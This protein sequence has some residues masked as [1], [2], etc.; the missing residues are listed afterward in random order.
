MP[1]A[2][3]RGCRHVP[4]AP[5]PHPATHPPNPTRRHVPPPATARSSQ[6][7]GTAAVMSIQ[8]RSIG[9]NAQSRSLVDDENL[10]TVGTQAPAKLA[11][12]SWNDASTL[13]L[14]LALALVPSCW[15]TQSSISSYLLFIAR[16]RSVVYRLSRS[17]K[18]VIFHS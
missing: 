14:N 4:P 13:V 5:P 3:R 2:I 8:M 18:G 9:R 7:L 6:V 10:K 12:Q 16:C 11:M 17:L 15:I 1:A